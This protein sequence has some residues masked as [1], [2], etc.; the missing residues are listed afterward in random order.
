M[1]PGAWF[2]TDFTEQT[3]IA[4]PGSVLRYSS[5][6]SAFVRRSADQRTMGKMGKGFANA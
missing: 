5:L 4:M 6:P 3:G 2:P 1:P